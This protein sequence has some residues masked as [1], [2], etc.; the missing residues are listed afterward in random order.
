LLWRVAP[1]AWMLLVFLLSS[2][3]DLGDPFEL[4]A[5]LPMDKL[6]HGLLFGVLS[7][8]LYLAGM[9]V[10]PAV[11]VAATYGLIDEFHQMFVPGR[12]PDLRDWLA[13]LAGAALGAWIVRFPARQLGSA[14]NSVE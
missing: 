12:S 6:A 7:A 9:R 2:R 1:L 10:F 4:P 3:S 5:W 14:P 8:L 11:L 13:D